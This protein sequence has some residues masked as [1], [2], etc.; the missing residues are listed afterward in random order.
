M[1]RF[2]LRVVSAVALVLSGASCSDRVTSGSDRVARIAIIPE[3]SAADQGIFRSLSSFA[4][5]IDNVHIVI[6]RPATETAL[7]D[8]TVQFPVTSSQIAISIPV[9]LDATE[10]TLSAFIELRSATIVLFSGS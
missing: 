5:A 4:L 9:R 7:V 1:H 6:F 2:T 8:T 3:L 10:E